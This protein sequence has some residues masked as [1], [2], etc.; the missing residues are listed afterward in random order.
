M[1]MG[2]TDG[3]TK[4]WTDRV[5]YY[6]IDNY[7]YSYGTCDVTYRVIQDK[8]ENCR[9]LFETENNRWGSKT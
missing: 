2:R 9:W 8:L 3:Q 7:S 1:C 5:L 4:R 6:Y